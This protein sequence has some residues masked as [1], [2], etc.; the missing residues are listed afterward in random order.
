MSAKDILDMIRARQDDSSWRAKWKADVLGEDYQEDEKE[1][2]NPLTA[3]EWQEFKRKFVEE[4][5]GEKIQR[6]GL[7]HS[8]LLRYIKDSYREGDE[9]D[10]GKKLRAFLNSL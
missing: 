1:I 4:Y 10:D 2:W 6:D 3:D 5:G 8:E 9:H 7:T